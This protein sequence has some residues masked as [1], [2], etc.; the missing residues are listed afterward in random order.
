MLKK[1]T[2]LLLSC[3]LLQAKVL[4]WDLG[5]VLFYPD[6]LGVAQEVGLSNFLSYMVL[7]GRNPNCQGVLFDVLEQMMKPEK[8]IR[9]CAGTAEGAPLPTIMCHWQAGTITGKDIIERSKP[10]IKRLHK[11]G[12]FDSDREMR[13]IKRT[14]RAM[15]D[16]D[17]LA[18]NVFPLEKGMK[19]LKE[20]SR[21]KNK[22]GTKK[23][24][25]F[26]FS[27]W[28]HLSFDICYRM[29]RRCFRFFEGIVISG[30]I[31]CIKPRAESYEYILKK[32]NL[33]PHDCILIDDQAI[34]AE[35]ARKCGMNA[36]LIKDDDYD[37]LRRTLKAL[38]A[39]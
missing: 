2:I 28:D 8:G 26:A 16:P 39:L 19:L 18:R 9:E 20:C 10:H 5:G 14:I 24:R 31:G 33:N 13:L 1:F 6:K 4:L 29:H 11:Q 34:N 12:Y 32:Y 15:F 37:Q 35:G 22:D 23:N 27:N 21:A 36:V 30:H 38:G 25:I 3:S 17:I 7:D